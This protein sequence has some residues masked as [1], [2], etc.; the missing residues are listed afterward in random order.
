MLRYGS[1]MNAPELINLLKGLKLPLFFLNMASAGLGVRIDSELTSFR[2][3][4]E[5]ELSGCIFKRININVSSFKMLSKSDDNKCILA[6]L[7]R[8]NID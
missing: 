6:L 4:I 3:K 7:L 2:I 8:L 1:F 5:S